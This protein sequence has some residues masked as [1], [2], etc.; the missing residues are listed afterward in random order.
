MDLIDHTKVTCRER[1]HKPASL[2]WVAAMLA[3]ADKV[4]LVHRTEYHDDESET[5]TYYLE[6]TPEQFARLKGA[7][8]A[9]TA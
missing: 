2:R 3:D 7:L 4:P 6:L 8:R 1:W 5:D 9:R